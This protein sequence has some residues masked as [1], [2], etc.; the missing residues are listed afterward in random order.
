MSD[1]KIRKPPGTIFIRLKY[2]SDTGPG[3]EKGL[4]DPLRK[5]LVLV[6]PTGVSSGKSPHPSVQS[7]RESC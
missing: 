3:L 7:T 4:P 2:G 1:N 5:L 6:G